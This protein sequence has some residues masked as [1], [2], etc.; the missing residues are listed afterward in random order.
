MLGLVLVQVCGFR[1]LLWQR[2]AGKECVTKG[3]YEFQTAQRAV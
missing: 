3:S 2:R 1:T